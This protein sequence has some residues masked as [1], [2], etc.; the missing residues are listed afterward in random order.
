MEAKLVEGS[1]LDRVMLAGLVDGA[2]A[3]I[4]LAARP[5]VPRSLADPLRTSR[6]TPLGPS[7]CLSLPPEIARCDHGVVF[8]D[9]RGAPES[10]KHEHLRPAR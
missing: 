8:V 2:D 1:I 9:L 7:V 3:V 5:S 4:H 10:P 6:S